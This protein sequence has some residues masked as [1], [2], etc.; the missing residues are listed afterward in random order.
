MYTVTPAHLF[1]NVDILGDD[2]GTE[3]QTRLLLTRKTA[4]TKTVHNVHSLY[5]MYTVTPA[6]L[7]DNVDILGDDRTPDQA[8]INEEDSV[9]KD[10]TQ[11]TR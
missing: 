11:C 5:T 3:P 10:C 2:R 8:G 7:F 6:Q 9:H 1:D 4:N